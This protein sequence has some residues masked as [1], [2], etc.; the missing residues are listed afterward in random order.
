MGL[1][2][3][4]R[5]PPSALPCSKGRM[6]L[7][8]KRER[9]G[10]IAGLLPGILWGQIPII[11]ALFFDDV[12]LRGSKTG[13]AASIG[14]LSMMVFRLMMTG[15]LVRQAG[16]KQPNN[17]PTSKSSFVVTGKEVVAF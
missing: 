10:I 1:N 3:N 15:E 8:E 11:M 12:T 14:S 2:V 6:N 7:D 4:V 5:K 9:S 16:N 13:W 17:W